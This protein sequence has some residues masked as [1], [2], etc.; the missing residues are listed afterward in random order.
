MENI[1]GNIIENGEGDIEDEE[2]EEEWEK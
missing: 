1:E 2:G